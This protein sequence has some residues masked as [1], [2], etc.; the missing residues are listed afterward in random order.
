VKVV[1]LITP[2]AELVTVAGFVVTVVLS[3]FTV[4][5]LLAPKP[6]PVSV[7]VVPMM[8]DVGDSVIVPPTVKVAVAVLVPP[9]TV[10][11]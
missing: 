7:T 2:D 8:P 3:N 1:E 4:I 11:V 5:V 9:V 10:T 6:D